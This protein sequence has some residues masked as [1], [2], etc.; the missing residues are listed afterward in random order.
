M[1]LCYKYVVF[2]K[3]K[4][5]I[6]IFIIRKKHIATMKQTIRLTESELKGMIRNILKEA[7]SYG[8]S[9]DES[10]AEEAYN[11]AAQYF[12]NEDLNAQIVGAMSKEELAH[13]L[14][15]IFRMHDF[16]EW[17]E[18]QR[19]SLMEMAETENSNFDKEKIYDLAL[20]MENNRSVYSNVE[21]VARAIEKKIKRGINPD[22]E[23]L[24]SS[25]VVAKIV[26]DFLSQ[27]RAN[28]T[29][30]ERKELHHWC[31]SQIFHFL[32][33]NGVLNG[34]TISK[35]ENTPYYNIGDFFEN[36]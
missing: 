1:A 6:F 24:A 33:D 12:G 23:Y 30:A 2:Q 5:V 18:Y 27:V 4:K 3:E 11:L 26:R 22:F 32:N 20:N 21:A 13:C 15:Y 16:K 7:E 25:S 31:A 10:E 19:N 29:T 34:E 8:W 17:E 28:V 9:V 35:F 14:A 36:F